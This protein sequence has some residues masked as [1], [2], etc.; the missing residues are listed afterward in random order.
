MKKLVLIGNPVGHSMSPIMHN[1][2]LKHLGLDKNFNY[3]KRDVK[4][5]DLSSFVDELRNE[6]VYGA[7]VTIPHKVNVM[8]YVD[9]LTKEAY[10]IGAVNTIFLEEDKVIG[11][12]T[13]GIGC[14]EAL[15]EKG[16]KV[17]NKNILILG[18]GGAAKALAITFG[19][20]NAKSVSILNRTVKKA[21][22]LSTDVKEKTDADSD[23]SGL[24]NLNDFIQKSDILINST[25]VGMKGEF[26]N[27]TIA[28]KGFLRKNLV[29]MDIVYNPIKTRLIKDAEDVGCKVV[30]GLGMLLYQGAEG[31]EIWT[32]RK[33]PVKVMKR[34]LKE[35]LKAVK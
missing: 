34:A 7:N 31:F 17:K 3:S 11:H 5:K 30:E 27:K 15:N 1:A 19:I 23:F 14:L 4:D 32:K 33:A 9:G 8:K 26:E 25:P 21:K 10:L 29:V 2:A 20:N 24:S 28:K 6:R 35:E 22:K 16:V 18:A 12:N 13:D